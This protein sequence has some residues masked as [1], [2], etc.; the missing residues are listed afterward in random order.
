MGAA[1]SVQLALIARCIF[2][3]EGQT[4]VSLQ[5]SI[6]MLEKLKLNILGLSYWNTRY[7]FL[8]ILT[9]DT[10]YRVLELFSYVFVYILG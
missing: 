3:L 1:V 9:E 7:A 8:M 6:K 10:S 5:Y 4:K 2:K